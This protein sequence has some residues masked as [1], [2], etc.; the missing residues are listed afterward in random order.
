VKRGLSTPP[1]PAPAPEENGQVLP[2]P[3]ELTAN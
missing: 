1:V 3:G 2:K